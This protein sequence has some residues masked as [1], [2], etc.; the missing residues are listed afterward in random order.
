[1]LKLLSYILKNG[2]ATVSK[3]SPPLTPD[4]NGMPALSKEPCSGSECNAC[5]KACPT[6]AIEVSNAST[7]GKISL[8]LGK[9]IGCHL[10]IDVCPTGTIVENHSTMIA[11]KER[12]DLILRN[13]QSNLADS[14]K[15][16]AKPPSTTQSL[17]ILFPDANKN[18]S[19]IKENL[20]RQSLHAR[21]VC[22]GCSACD[23]EIGA[24][25]NPVFDL[26]R[27]GVHIVAS[28]RFADALLVTG[29]VGKGM[30][31][32]LLRCY[33][34]MPDPKVVVAVGTCAISGGVH[35]GGYAEANGVDKH[36]PVAVYIPGC[37]PH[38]W[39]IIHGI[40]LAMGKINDP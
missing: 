17:S 22:T 37:P 29:P 19:V 26:E 40:L 4:A 30:R 25:T 7:G 15:K 21:V 2:I 36:L 20:F 34:A 32:S 14:T 1:M 31:D 28:P 23:M 39:T 24:C 38:P 5:A 9:C 18:D 11:K 33:S 27:F 3:P 13:D 6:S 10:C 16:K 12:K 8:D 35:Q